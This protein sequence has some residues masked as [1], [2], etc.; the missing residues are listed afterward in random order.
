MPK[1]MMMQAMEAKMRSRLLQRSLSS[2]KASLPE[3]AGE[4]G[5]C[6]VGRWES[7]PPE[8]HHPGESQIWWQ[9][10]F[11]CVDGGLEGIPPGLLEL[12]PRSV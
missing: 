9:E 5:M 12:L 10:E 8:D 11:D 3:V 1:A 2:G 4:K 7:N 6:A